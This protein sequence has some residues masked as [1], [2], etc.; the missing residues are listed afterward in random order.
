MKRILGLAL[1]AA[2]ATGLVMLVAC[3]TTYEYNQNVTIKPS[4]AGQ[5]PEVTITQS[6]EGTTTNSGDVE[7]AADADLSAL[8]G[9]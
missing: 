5:I 9:N 6:Q 3:G 2:I 8:P 4:E 7:A 1:W